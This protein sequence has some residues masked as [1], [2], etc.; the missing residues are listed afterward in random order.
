MARIT[1]ILGL[2]VLGT[3]IAWAGTSGMVGT[4]EI[5]GR[6]YTSPLAGGLEYSFQNMRIE[7]GYDDSLAKYSQWSRKDW[8]TLQDVLACMDN[9]TDPSPFI[10]DGMPTPFWQ[11]LPDSTV[12]VIYET[13]LPDGEKIT[14]D[15]DPIPE[16][17]DLALSLYTGEI[18]NLNQN[19]WL[20]FDFR[21]NYNQASV[22]GF[23]MDRNPGEPD[24]FLNFD[25]TASKIK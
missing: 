17:H 19:I 12:G 23:A 2:L 6:V 14:F 10:T 5:S 22:G 7:I 25:A 15:S 9:G 13:Y 11:L 20:T 24:L 4:W 8:Q 1:A 21:A 3:N 18:N 16:G